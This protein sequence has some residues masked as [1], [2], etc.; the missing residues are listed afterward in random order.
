M[1]LTA[2]AYSMLIGGESAE[3]SSG[4]RFVRESPAHDVVV[5]SY[6]SATVDDVD[7]AI[8]TARDAFDRGSWPR[9]SGAVR[10]RLLRRV[11]EL[12]G[13]AAAA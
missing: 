5:G 8:A 10:A 9:E 2:T 7:R 12:I 1:T 4:E 3:A 6:P 13:A 11:A